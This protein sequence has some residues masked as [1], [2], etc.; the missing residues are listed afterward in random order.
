MHT[1]KVI[2]TLEA[3]QSHAAGWD[4]IVGFL[5]PLHHAWSISS[6]DCLSMLHTFVYDSYMMFLLSFVHR[7]QI[8]FRLWHQ[9]RT[10]IFLCF[11]QL[12]LS[13]IA[14]SHFINIY[15]LWN[16]ISPEIL[17][18]HKA[19]ILLWYKRNN[20]VRIGSLCDPRSY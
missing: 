20:N 11:L 10:I 2:S 8:A 1:T 7:I 4:V 13:T 18:T 5:L 15:F 14:G 16:S 3:I 17:Q 9:P 6:N 12:P 19:L